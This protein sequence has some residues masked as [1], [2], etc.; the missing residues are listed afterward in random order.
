MVLSKW[1]AT[2]SATRLGT[3]WKFLAIYFIAEVAQISGNL[4][5]LFEKHHFW[6]TNYCVYI[7]C[8][9]CGNRATFYST[10]LVTRCERFFPP[11]CCLLLLPFESS[12]VEWEPVSDF[13]DKT[14]N[15]DND[16]DHDHIMSKWQTHRCKRMGW[17]SP[18]GIRLLKLAAMAGAERTAWP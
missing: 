10:N 17:S 12:W 7:F 2:F 15:G 5:G 11:K 14:W 9:I 8:N 4:F 13:E 16:N 6:S 18:G 3:F 1:S